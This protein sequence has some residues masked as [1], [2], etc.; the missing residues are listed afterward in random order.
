MLKEKEIINIDFQEELLLQ[1]LHHY[2]PSQNPIKDFVHHNSLHS[3]QEF[4]F[5]EAIKRASKIFGYKGYLQLNEYRKLFQQGKISEDAIEAIISKHYG[6]NE[7]EQWK[8]KLIHQEYCEEI[9]QRIGRLRNQWKEKMYINLDK[10]TF[11]VLFRMISNYLDQ[12]ISIWNFPITNVSFLEAVKLLEQNTNNSIFKTQKAKELLFSNDLSL[13]KLLKLIVGKESYFEYY[14]FDQQFSHP[15]WSGMVAVLEHNPSLL[16]DRRK[17]NL[18]EFI[19]FELLLELDVL[20][21]KYNDFWSPIGYKVKLEHTDIFK[22]VEDSELF[23][24]YKLWLEAYEWTYYSEVLS[25]LSHA[26]SVD[27]KEVTTKSFQAFFCIDDR[28]ISLRQHI[29]QLDNKCETFG[30]PGHFNL[31]TYYKP[32]KGKFLLKV[33]P[34]PL[35]PKHVIIEKHKEKKIKKDTH[36]SKKTQHA[37]WGLIYTQTLG[38]LSGFN[39]F[40]ILISPS[41]SSGTYYSFSHMHE[42]ADIEIDE[43]QT[44]IDGIKVGFSVEEMAEIVEDILKTT[45]LI[46][47]FAPL[48]YFIAHGAS[49][50]N[51]PYFAGYGCGA[52]VGRPGSA[53]ARAAAKMANKKE[54]RELL[55]SKGIYIPDNTQFVGGLHDTTRDEIKFY[56]VNLLSNENLKLHNQNIEIFNQA[57]VN[58][59]KE[60][61]RRFDN[62]PL[63]IP[64]NK[65]HQK[66]KERSVAL[67]EI[68]PEYNHAT[69]TLFI[70]GRRELTKHLF[71][72]RRAFL[73][74][75][76]YKIDIDG[77]LL[78][79]ILNAGAGVC[80]GINLEYYFSRVDTHRLGAGSKLPQNVVGLIGVS[81]GVD[82]D[83]RTGLPY[84]MVEIHDPLRMLTIIEQDQELVQ[85]VLNNNPNVKQWFKNNWMNLIVINP[86]NKTFY[87][88]LYK[89]DEFKKLEVLNKEIGTIHSLDEII[90]TSRENLPVC[91]IKN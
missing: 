33:C 85:S 28:E 89:S 81:N 67:F 58:N 19:I 49:S 23:E 76:N 64:K 80:A 24:V 57:L 82:G 53:N 14:V 42:T 37:L 2:L 39:L 18:K 1:K 69:N 8:N 86:Y 48:V 25:G 75:Y 41:H 91:I 9:P 30:T 59:A 74:S 87:E 5:H 12:G 73:N 11:P 72:D 63:N 36:F 13:Y 79:K 88:Y 52:C 54:V 45:G 27:D 16:F 56:D 40:K 46:D 31:L 7:I 61:A 44:D 29:E 35:T 32:D 6:K 90:S 65:V 10:E 84:Q 17:I 21:N 83:L 50:T 68:R 38:F 22:E 47:D 62:I 34:A 78:A 60:R 70:I 55:K 3:F 51:N 15:G 20:Y 66:I 26:L 77:S 43:N 4:P 71:L